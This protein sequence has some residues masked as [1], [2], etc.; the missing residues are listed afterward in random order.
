LG[1][2]ERER[3]ETSDDQANNK[4][5]DST[6]LFDDSRDGGDDQDDMANESDDDGDADRVEATPVRVGDV[7]S[8]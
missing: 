7:G 1:H 8:E 6:L 3:T 2:N 4:W 5:G